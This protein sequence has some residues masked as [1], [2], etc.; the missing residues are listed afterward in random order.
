MARRVREVGSARPA[1][2]RGRRLVLPDGNTPPDARSRANR[3]IGW[4][5]TTNRLLGADRELD[6]RGPFLAAL[7][8]HGRQV[9][10]STVSRWEAGLVDVADET[11]H[12]YEN[13]LGLPSGALVAVHSGIRRSLGA[14]RTRPR[15]RPD[16]GTLM[17]VDLEPLVHTLC[18]GS[19]TGGDWLDL[20]RTLNEFDL[21]RMSRDSW[22]GLSARLVEELGTAV[23]ISFVRRYEA[24]VD[25]IGRPEAVHHLTDA[26]AGYVTTP[27]VQSVFPVL[28]LLA[29]ID[30]PKAGQLAT[31]LLDSEN[32]VVRLAS[33]WTVAVKLARHHRS[34]VDDRRLEH[35][36]CEGLRNG[37]S[38]SDQLDSANLAVHLPADSWGR[39]RESLPAND[40]AIALVDGARRHGE[41]LV[42]D[43]VCDIVD[44][45][46][47]TVAADAHPAVTSGDDP[48]LRTLLRE[49]VLDADSARRHHALLTL[50]ASPYAESLARAG[51]SLAHSELPVL[52]TR[53]QE[54]LIML[55]GVE[56]GTAPLEQA[57][58]ED[59]EAIRARALIAIGLRPSGIDASEDAVIV[60]HTVDSAAPMDRA[61]G[62]F[63]LGMTG[64]ESLDGL[65]THDELGPAARWWDANGPALHDVDVAP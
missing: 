19:G 24:A 27:H 54:L 42:S 56:E 14:E 20:T 12:L 46:A 43:A 36:V 15:R 44:D 33:A 7:A 3:R 48:M 47:S 11:A 64:S 5:L 8:E 1:S 30:D 63:A 57:L 21:V 22:A 2:R 32:P 58:A 62:L 41:L 6:R 10:A 37:E 17:S 29:D 23:G 50:G 9:D 13:V 65:T 4:L 18:S 39:I 28:A 51:R 61:A 49:A 59:R 45:V 16:D 60:D 53:M 38:V 34:G 52:A 40:A 25:L 35:H 26:I 55:G 31:Q